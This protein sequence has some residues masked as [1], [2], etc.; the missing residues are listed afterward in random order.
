MIPDVRTEEKVIEV[1]KRVKKVN[2]ILTH[3]MVNS[4]MRSFLIEEC[5]KQ[6]VKQADLMGGLQISL[7]MILDWNL[8]T[9]RVSIIKLILGITR[10]S[11]RWNTP[12]IVMTG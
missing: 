2:G 6:Q 5:K 1:I 3:T 10:E 7:K 11:K 12:F 4:D 8:L 9:L